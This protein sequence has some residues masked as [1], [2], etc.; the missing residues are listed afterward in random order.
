MTDSQQSTITWLEFQRDVHSR[1]AMPDDW[2]YRGP[3]DL[4]LKEGKWYF[5]GRAKQFPHA[6]PKAC[7]RNAAMFAFE[8]CLPYV[9]GYATS[10][11]PVHHAW[12]LDH[13][14]R[15]LEVTWK[16]L[17]TDYF[18]VRFDPRLVYKGSVLFHKPNERIYRRKLKATK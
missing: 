4:L 13:D 2:Y 9:E 11:I 1:N 15:V 12:C 7:F 3:A 6:M 10:I 18:G 16:T 8:H 17:G 14:G 5:D